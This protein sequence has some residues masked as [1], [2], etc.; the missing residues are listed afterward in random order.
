MAIEDSVS[1]A[2]A[3]LSL[4]SSRQA[5]LVV[6]LILAIT[7]I[8][9]Y[10]V[11]LITTN[12][13]VADVLPRGDPNTAAAHNLTDHF[14]STFTQQ[15]TLQIHV[16]NGTGFKN[17]ERDNQ[18]LS[19]R[20]TSAD[21]GNITDE[22]YVRAME[23]MILFIQA[24]TEF[25]RSISISKLFALI[26]WTVAGG[27]DRATDDD[28]VLP[29]YGTPGSALQ[30]AVVER[31]VR[32]AILDAVDALA[33]P[34]WN[35]AGV[36][37]M[38][39]ADNELDMRVLGDQIIRAR[40][41][42]VAAVDAG[43]TTFTVFGS[44]NP[45]LFTVDL[46]IA[47]A[48]SS[49]LVEGDT[50]R[51]MPAIFAFI[52][53]CLF[54]A[55][56]NVRAIA[57]SITTLGISVTWTYGAMGYMGIA[58]NT[59]NMTI[60][61]LIMGVG[62]DYAIHMIN[63]FI[64][65]KAEGYSD[66]E[67]LRKAGGRA[68]LAMF[69]AT[70]TTILGLVVMM[71][72]PSLLMAQLGLLS[73]IA[74]GATYIL[75]LTFIP[76]ALTLLGGTER[77]GQSFTPSKAMPAMGRFIT[78]GR[79][80]VLLVVVLV[81]LAAYASSQSLR[82]EAFGDPGKNFPKDH[83]L[84]GTDS[85]R[86][87]HEQ[88]LRYFYEMDN[89]DVK[90]NILVFEGP[91]I[92]SP[93]AM[94][95]YRTIEANLKVQPRVISDTLRTVPFF[96]E[97]WMTVKGGPEGAASGVVIGRLIEEG[98]LPPTVAPQVDA[99]PRTEQEIKDEVVAMFES[100]MGELAALIM[101]YPVVIE[102]PE[103]G[104]AAMTFS[105]RAATFEEAKEVWDQVW[106]AVAAADAQFGG[107]PPEGVRVAFVGNTATNFLFQDQQLPW[108]FYMSIA[109]TII[110]AVLVAAFTRSFRATFVAV[111]M[112]SLT[113]LWWF[114]ILPLMGIGLAITLMLP[115]VFIFN[116]GTDYAV[117]I[118][119]NLKKVKNTRTVF[120]TTGKA[121]LF[122]AVTTIGAFLIFILIRNVAVSRTMVAT[123]VAILIIFV[124]TLVII[125]IFYPVR[126]RGWDPKVDERKRLE[127]KQARQAA[128]EAK[129]PVPAIKRP[130]ETP[131]PAVKR[132]KTA[133]ADTN[134]R[135]T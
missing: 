75:A 70:L 38:P 113:S 123:A 26:N 32:T 15:V 47:N 11:G 41:R 22:V 7:V 34:S 116:I 6:A 69:I 24:E 23:E 45:P 112:A 104:M 39:E 4:W 65:H 49:N 76:A 13:D 21:A 66:A 61:P 27:E 57:I 53:A 103:R 91:R 125:P 14:R 134:R 35:H 2:I 107:H 43:E 114:G 115:I 30:Y 78:R 129:R 33:S 37:F 1:K 31:T 42:Y 51:L 97:T 105:V 16:D 82:P 73:A 108:L 60:V 20:A 102:N 9:G 127:R 5:K 62:I 3:S 83:P 44:S 89:P 52:I 119:W 74:I 117:H 86:A 28:F 128:R 126:H 72:S 135:S 48:H 88:G 54:V 18:L 109:S 19:Y 36:L 132:R 100:P 56:R 59:L 8:M 12:V 81:S 77:M 40:D 93:E 92:L 10:G 106:Q 111:G 90:A 64:E 29:G 55:F 95:Y 46:P 17:W 87:E 94:A 84:Y 120:E 124:A 79:F 96:L 118:I 25:S 133:W 50:L 63:E 58:L 67:A 121:I 99:F 71:L 101:N 131:T 68:G 98:L 110:L 80:A 130:K 85:I 122:S